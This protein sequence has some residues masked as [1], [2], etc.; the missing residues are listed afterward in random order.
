VSF[1][2]ASAS[3]ACRY[4]WISEKNKPFVEYLFYLAG[5]KVK[6]IWGVKKL[7][8]AEQSKRWILESLTFDYGE[9]RYYLYAKAAI[10]YRMRNTN[11]TYTYTPTGESYESPGWTSKTVSDAIRLDNKLD[12]FYHNRATLY[13]ARAGHQN[14]VEYRDPT[15]SWYVIGKHRFYD[16]DTRRSLDLPDTSAINCNEGELGFEV[17]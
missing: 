1:A 13:S 3:R 5:A 4:D 14:I 6:D 2:L 8:K 15:V 17:R 12:I 11:G 7:S 10:Y 9:A 16:P